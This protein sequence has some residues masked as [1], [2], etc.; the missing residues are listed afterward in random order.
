MKCRFG[1]K[2]SNWKQGYQKFID[3]KTKIKTA[4]LFQQRQCQRCGYVQREYV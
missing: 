1:H 4:E 3:T 2:W